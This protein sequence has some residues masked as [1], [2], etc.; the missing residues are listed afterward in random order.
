MSI[1]IGTV[2]PQKK[3][4]FYRHAVCSLRRSKRVF[5]TKKFSFQFP[6]LGLCQRV[7]S[8][9][10]CMYVHMYMLVWV[11]S[12]LLLL[13]F[14]PTF[15][16]PGRQRRK[17]EFW[18]EKKNKVKDYNP[19]TNTEKYTNLTPNFIP[20]P[21]EKLSLSLSPLLGC[22]QSWDSHHL[23][24]NETACTSAVLSYIVYL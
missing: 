6:Y 20:S 16:R 2:C 9:Y 19:R 24:S 11:F 15:S 12:S 21:R 5:P 8:V 17:R 7:Y 13:L 23:K 18:R 4:C 22:I 10:T 1:Y 14:S 3:K